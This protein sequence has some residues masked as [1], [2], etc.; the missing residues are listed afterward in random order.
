MYKCVY[1]HETLVTGGSPGPLFLP[2]PFR[3]VI[4]L[5]IEEVIVNYNSGYDYSTVM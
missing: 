5:N 2:T 1:F 4:L 3:G